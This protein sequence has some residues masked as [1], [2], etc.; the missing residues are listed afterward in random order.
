MLYE[1]ITSVATTF[2][3]SILLMVFV[4]PNFETLFLYMFYSAN[5]FVGPILFALLKK[6][7]NFYAVVISMIFGFTYPAISI[8]AQNTEYIGKYP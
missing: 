3:M 8:F 1:V 2:S 7:I 5:G 4:N 6:Q